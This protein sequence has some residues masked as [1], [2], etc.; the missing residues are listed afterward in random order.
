MKSREQALSDTPVSFTVTLT[1]K[2]DDAEKLWIAAAERALASPGM[3]LADVLDTIGPRED[4]SISDC[5]AML[6]APADLPGCLLDDFAVR[7]TAA[8]VPLGVQ[9]MQ[10]PERSLALLPA[11]NG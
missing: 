3:T 2:V 4:P 5:I 11:A 9:L 8:P 1:L 7:E 6:A 10:M